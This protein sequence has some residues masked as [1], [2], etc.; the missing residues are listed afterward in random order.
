VTRIAFLLWPDTFEDWYGPLDISR[1]NY[2]ADYD[3]EWSITLARALAQGGVDVHLVHGTLGDALTAKQV[4]SGATAHFVPTTPAYRALRKLLWGHRWWERTQWLTPATAV[5]STL[6][7]RLVRHLARLRPDVVVVQDYETLRYDIAAPLLR[8]AGLPVVG[9][10]TGASARPSRAPWKGL[11]RRLARQL[12]A[13]HEAEA[14]RL[15]ARGHEDVQVW[16]VPVRTDVF[17]PADRAAARVQ[18]G[19]DPSDRIVFAAARLHPVK[20]LPLLADACHD[21]GATLVIAGEGSER[22]LLRNRGEDEVRLLGWQDI[23]GLVTWYAAA[24]VVALS[25][26]HEGQPIA[27]LEAFACGRGVVATAVGGVPEV[28]RDGETGWL[29]PARDREALATALGKALAARATADGYGLAGRALVL[30]EHTEHA[31]A[32]SFTAMVGL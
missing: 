20:N 32:D 22:K 19:I 13:V 26:N 4:P 3:G 1:S 9:L 28:V 6:S 5:A 8:A 29:V 7:V 15:R 23:E 10:D 24:D 11:T 21:V 25:S 31:V 2:L 17:V 27:V 30:R 14:D 18:L 16:P 12:L